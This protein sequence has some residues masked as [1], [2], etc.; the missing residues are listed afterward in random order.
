MPWHKS[1]DAA[2]S[3]NVNM[4]H[5][6]VFFSNTLQWVEYSNN[7]QHNKHQLL[8]NDILN[9][10][11]LHHIFYKSTY[12]SVRCGG[13]STFTCTFSMYTSPILTQRGQVT[14][15]VEV[16]QWLGCV[17]VSA[18]YLMIIAGSCG[19]NQCAESHSRNVS[20]GRRCWFVTTCTVVWTK[21]IASLRLRLI[22]GG[23]VWI[24]VN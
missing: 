1:P 10:W 19:M 18:T 7:I 9:W 11:I 8:F 4:F 20:V 15:L 3:N 14:E 17:T 23:N 24:A 12:L 22:P 21:K 16:S 6:N 5:S 2:V 13:K